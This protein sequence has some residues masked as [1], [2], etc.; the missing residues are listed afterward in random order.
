MSARLYQP[1]SAG[2]PASQQRLTEQTLAQQQLH[3]YSVCH[4]WHQA[5]LAQ[6]RT[7]LP[8]ARNSV[9]AHK[10]LA[11]EAAS[12]CTGLALPFIGASR[13]MGDGR[14]VKGVRA[15]AY[16][17]GTRSKEERT[18]LQSLSDSV[19]RFEVKSVWTH[20]LAT[21]GYNTQRHSRHTSRSTRKWKEG[22]K[23][24]SI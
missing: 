22:R 8:S 14:G 1:P 11:S 13:H 4:C 23:D 2:M 3:V 12:T 21:Y 5:Q 19:T 6:A 9:F 16:F 20:A 15:V 10:V 17:N 7:C 18:R 24:A